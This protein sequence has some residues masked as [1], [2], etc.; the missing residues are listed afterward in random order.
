MADPVTIIGAASL[1]LGAISA[2]VGVVG[3]QASAKAQSENA[4]YQAQVAKNDQIIAS[5]NAEFSIQAGQAKAADEAL[6][7][8]QKQGAVLTGLAANGLDVNSGTPL[9][10]EDTEKETGALGTQRVIDAS[11]LQAY[12][13]RSQGSNFGATAGLDTAEASQA[14]TAGNLAAAGGLIGGASSVG[15]NY[16]KLSQ[17]GAFSNTTPT[18]TT[19]ANGG[20]PKF[21]DDSNDF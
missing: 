6:K 12:G 4:N 8:R 2:G 3:A 5:Q 21:T 18:V 15:L 1:A 19:N 10:V 17:S 13:Y 16:S 11:S 7:N 9:A 20:V 14:T